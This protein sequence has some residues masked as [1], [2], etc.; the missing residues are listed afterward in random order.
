MTQYALPDLRYRKTEF[1]EAV[2][3]VWNWADAEARFRAVKDM[4][5]RLPGTSRH[6]G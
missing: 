6:T 3:N 2:W 4:D 5:V 1:F